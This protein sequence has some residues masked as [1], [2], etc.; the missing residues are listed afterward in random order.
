MAAESELSAFLRYFVERYDGKLTG[1][2]LDRLEVQSQQTN[3][4]LGAI[5]AKLSDFTT[6]LSALSADVAA[7]K[8]KSDASGAVTAENEALK[9]QVADLKAAL[10][11]AKAEGGMTA[12]EE[13]QVLSSIQAL[14]SQIHEAPA[15]P[16][17]PTV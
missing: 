13:E 7:V 16:A 3:T 8:A 10:E 11:A 12:A 2:R 17:E 9:A 4:N 15:T 5:M 6:I 1:E 14:E